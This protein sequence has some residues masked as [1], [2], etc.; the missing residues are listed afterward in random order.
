MCVFLLF[1]YATQ[2]I[3][4]DGSFFVIGGRR[5]FTYEFLSP[6]GT[7]DLKSFTFDFLRETTDLAENNLYP[8]VHLS[9]DG[10]L[11]IFA[12]NRSILFNPTTQ[13]IL[14]EF[15]VLPGGSRNYPAS[16]MS[17]LLPLNLQDGNAEAEVLVCGGAKPEAFGLAENKTFLPALED[18]GRIDIKNPNSDWKI[19]TMP[20]RRV[21]GDMLILPTGDILMINGAKKGTSAWDAADVPNLTPVLYSPEKPV[22]DRFKELEPSSIPRMYHSTSAVLP[23][24]KILVA[25][26]NT[27]PDYKFKGVKYPTEM[28]VEKF[29]PPYLDQSLQDRKPEILLEYSQAALT[30]GESFKVKVKFSNDWEVDRTDMKV[31]MYA[32]PFT[33]HGY[34]MNQRLLILETSSVGRTFLGF[35][36]VVAT[37]PPSGTVAPP[38]YY[39]LYVVHRGVPSTGMW[40]QIQ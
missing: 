24:G 15:P 20:S 19:E 22:N 40:V 7:G 3:L 25:G 14:R 10:N 39:L 1:R 31:T 38:G 18:C 36:D 4:P 34:S 13:K 27:N 6:Q 28:R 9:P 5:T 35:Y 17:A 2:Q 33:T 16:G 32:P 8:F 37:A 12:N 11:F 30:Y 23:D 29:S 21:M 26:S